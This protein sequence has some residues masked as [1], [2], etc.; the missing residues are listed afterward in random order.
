MAHYFIDNRKQP[1]GAHEV[2]SQGCSRMATDKHYLGDFGHFLEA[3]ME[4]RKTHWDTSGCVRC[5]P[6]SGDASRPE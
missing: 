5:L 2:H 1:D 3:M 4:A 6:E